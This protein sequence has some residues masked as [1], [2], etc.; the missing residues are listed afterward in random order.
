MNHESREG[1]RGHRG[2][3]FE[4]WGPESRMWGERAPGARRR[5][6]DVRPLLLAAL[7]DGAAH[8]YELIRRL[9]EKSGGQ[10]RPSAGSVYP[11]LQQLEDEGLVSGREQD[12]RNV[13]ELTEAGRAEAD[14]DALQRLAGDRPEGGPHSELRTELHQ[15]HLAARQVAVAGTAEQ[16]TEAVG[17]VRRARQDIYRLLAGE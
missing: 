1:R 12:G 8:G 13:Y 5:R 17:L 15:L 11:T 7:L 14:A 16:V 9:E 10:W 3:S 4:G 2:R 6:G